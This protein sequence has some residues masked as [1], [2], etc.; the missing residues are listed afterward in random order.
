MG[1][2]DYLLHDEHGDKMKIIQIYRVSRIRYYMSKCD[3][4][5]TS[6]QVPDKPICQ[7]RIGV[8]DSF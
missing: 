6:C 2:T 7:C 5:D 8:I 4:T 1:R 3:I